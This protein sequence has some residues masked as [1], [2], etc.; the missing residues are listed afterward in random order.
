MCIISYTVKSE[1][2][3]K[4]QN[5]PIKRDLKCFISSGCSTAIMDKIVVKLPQLFILKGN[6]LRRQLAIIVVLISG[7]KMLKQ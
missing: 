3:E 7:L 4:K 2:T 1:S 5:I 6:S